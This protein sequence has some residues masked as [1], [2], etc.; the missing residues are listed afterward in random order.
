MPPMESQEQ[1]DEFLFSATGARPKTTVTVKPK[2]PKEGMIYLVSNENQEFE[3]LREAANLSPTIEDL[4]KDGRT[5]IPLNLSS[6]VLKKVVE[7]LETKYKY[8][9]GDTSKTDFEIDRSIILDMLA[10]A[11][12]LDC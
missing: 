8:K 6:P 7:Y 10:A 3:I 11:E 12:Y 1:R 2:F 5:R 4:S 9:N